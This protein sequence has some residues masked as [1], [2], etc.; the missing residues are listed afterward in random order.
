MAT[1]VDLQGAGAGT[2]FAALG[3]GTDALVGVRLL[4]LLI[5]GGC[6]GGAGALAA[7][8][9]VQEVGLQIPLAAVPNSAVLTG[10]NIFCG[11]E[12]WVKPEGTSWQQRG[13]VCNLGQGSGLCKV[14]A[15]PW[16]PPASSCSEQ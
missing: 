11:G 3:E 8:A 7:G 9:V 16:L 13:S 2:A 4:G 12:R 1:H 10:E 6:G 14:G 15:L 5:N